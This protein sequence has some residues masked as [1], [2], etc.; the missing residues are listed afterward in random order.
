MRGSRPILR[1]AAA[2]KTFETIPVID[3]SSIWSEKAEDR[4]MVASQIGRACRD[5]GFFYAQNHS[6]PQTLIDETFDAAKTFF[7]LPHEDKMEVHLHKNPA[8]RGFDPVYE[9]KFEG[10]GKGGISSPRARNVSCAVLML[11]G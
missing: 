8:Y 10:R 11:D 9:T 7:K 6:I 2:K 3:V 4:N 5:V 1:G